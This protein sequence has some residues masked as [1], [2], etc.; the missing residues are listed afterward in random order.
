MDQEDCRAG[1][2]V[3]GSE[4]YLIE[5][6]IV[7]LDEYLFFINDVRPAP[8]VV[9]YLRATRDTADGW[10]FIRRVQTLLKK[11]ALLMSVFVSV[12]MKLSTI[13]YN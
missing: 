7:V 11:G 3:R 1:G 2:R 10:L 13:Q 6:C 9:Y 12:L 5:V 8:K 4:R